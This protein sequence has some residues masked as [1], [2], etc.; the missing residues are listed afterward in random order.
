MNWTKYVLIGGVLCLNNLVTPV[1]LGQTSQQVAPVEGR[2]TVDGSVQ[3]AQTKT[4]VMGA[5][6][7]AKSEDGIVRDQQVTKQMEITH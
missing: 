2:T 6:V 1:V 5:T 3:D 4:P 7:V